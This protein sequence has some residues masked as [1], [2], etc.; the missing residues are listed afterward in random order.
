MT[1]DARLLAAMAASKALTTGLRV[2]RRG[3][4]TALP[5]LVANRIDPRLLD[6][7]AGRLPSGAIVVAGTNGKTTTTRML[8]GMLESAGRSVVHN[9]SGSNL[10][11]GISSA[12]AEQMTLFGT[13]GA[14]IGVIETDENA[15]PD[16]VRRVQPRVILLL[17]L[18]R[19]QLDRYGELE[20]IANHWRGVIR[21]LTNDVTLVV[22]ADDPN[23]AALAAESGARVVTFG[24]DETGYELPELP[25][26]SDAAVC[27]VCESPLVYDALFVSHLGD[28]HCPNCGNRRPPLDIV[29]REIAIRGTESLTMVVRDERDGHEAHEVQ[30]EVALPGVYNAY[31]ALAAV[32]AARVLG[33]G[34]R[35]ILET[36]RTFR[37]AFG[38]LERVE[39]AGRSLL[40]AL[41][42]NPVGFNEVL[43]MMTASP[44]TGPLVIGINDLD[45]D[46]RDVS[47]LWDV[48]F[49]VLAGEQHS[50]PIFAVGIRGHDLAVRL[51]YAGVPTARLDACAAAKPLADALDHVINQTDTGDEIFLLLTYTALLQLRQSLADRGAVAEFW[52]Q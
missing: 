42:K 4:G 21:D 52:E 3:G 25:H 35:P 23:L 18:F 6:K 39:Y 43:R 48:D 13:G 47:W 50:A 30:A 31:N 26:A 46:G 12:F 24:L 2:S 28:Y 16:V 20:T 36:L 11:R 40:L 45:A 17:N 27:R 22:N 38:R 1:R 51:K 7:L 19:D 15:F 14:E 8:A 29:A 10:V 5:G 49:E 41:A 34:F 9:R 33:V 37:A 32:A 44:L